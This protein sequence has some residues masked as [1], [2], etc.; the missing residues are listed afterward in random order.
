[1]KEYSIVAVLWEDHTRV[2][3]EPLPDDPDT[4]VIPTL[5]VGIIVQETDKVIILVSN[6][7]RYTDTDDCNYLIIYKGSVVGRKE[8]GKIKL[9]KIR[10]R[11]RG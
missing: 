9:R 3:R 1:M 6:V 4:V 7:E 8:Y 2:E 5:S 11:R 10:G